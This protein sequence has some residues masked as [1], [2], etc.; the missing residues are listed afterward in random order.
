MMIF[1]CITESKLR[2]EENCSLPSEAI[3]LKNTQKIHS[4]KLKNRSA[5][6]YICT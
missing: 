1:H 2:P 4:T 6:M 5:T 3:F